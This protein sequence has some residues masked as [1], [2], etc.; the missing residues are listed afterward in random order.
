MQLA[1][2]ENININPTGRLSAGDTKSSAGQTQA[3][4]QGQGQ[5]VSSSGDAKRDSREPRFSSSTINERAGTRI[6]ARDARANVRYTFPI[7]WCAGYGV[8]ST[9]PVYFYRLHLI[10]LLYRTQF[11][12][13]L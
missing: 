12:A 4:G 3:Q 7:C 2:A 13:L 6:V 9:L 11:R 10:V 8:N 1:Y 5:D